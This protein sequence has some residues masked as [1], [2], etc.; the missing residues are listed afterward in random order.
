MKIR[1]RI[2]AAGRTSTF[3]HVG[4]VVV[5]G[6][7]PACECVFE[8]WASSGVSRYHARIELSAGGAT[9]ADAGSGNGTLHN[10]RPI[11]GPVPLRTGDRVGLGYTGPVL[12]VLEVDASAPVPPSNSLPVVALLAAGVAVVLAVGSV[13]VWLLR[14]PG[15]PPESTALAVAQRMPASEVVVVP[16]PP[17]P[18]Q[19]S[20]EAPKTLPAR[21]TRTGEART[22]GTHAPEREPSPPPP[23]N[24]PPLIDEEE[25]VVGRYVALPEWGP[26]VL[27]MRRGAAQP[28]AAL[29][30]EA[31]VRTGQ[32]LLA[33]PGYRSHIL[34]DSG[35]D[36]TLW[37]NVP[38]FCGVPPLLLE[39]SSTLRAPEKGT[40]LDLTLQW[41]RVRFANRKPSGAARVRLR[42]Q[43]EVWD[44]TLPKANSEVCAELW[45]ALSPVSSAAPAQRLP[46]ALGLFTNGP[47][48]VERTGT[49]H[50]HLEL[51]GRT[52]LAWTGA[53]GAALFREGMSDLPGWWKSPSADDALLAAVMLALEEWAGRLGSA[54]DLADKI[55]HEVDVSTDR[56]FREQGM[57][58]LATLDEV[59][60]LVNY[61]DDAKDSQ[62]RRSAAHALRAWLSRGGGRA[63]ELRQQLQTHVNSREKAALL[64][65]LLYPYTA[66]DLKHPDTYQKLI[67]QLNDDSLAVR[68]LA[69]WQLEELAPET[70]SQIPYN[71][72]D[73]PPQ[74]REV[75]TRWQQRLPA[76][77]LPG[78]VRERQ[79][80]GGSGAP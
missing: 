80:G 52:R 71:P 79:S 30:S 37:G 73:E 16:P 58:F 33:L 68:E 1:L 9:L 4:P 15:Q 59:P 26:S 67:A 38:Q 7:D 62:V 28:W 24:P 5:L 64:L 11:A 66:D 2:V 56:Q 12:T 65:G 55:Q 57:Y 75:L 41:G 6:R 49:R 21:E 22:V 23:T 27:L 40:D 20:K 25:K 60:Y 39:S 34:L 45:S 10:D 46:L 31:R 72:A 19:P 61:L 74:R 43:R 29:R 50:E 14:H 13:G 70:A 77:S 44:V 51:P 69:G 18:S 47:A 53:A 35:V 76:G 42:F 17:P 8:G 48:T 36:L 78:R 54:G 32:P 63:D 3:E